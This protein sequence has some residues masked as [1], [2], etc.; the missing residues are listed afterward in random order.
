MTWRGSACP[1]PV[2]PAR[3]TRLPAGHA[4]KVGLVPFRSPLEGA[5]VRIKSKGA[6]CVREVVAVEEMGTHLELVLAGMPRRAMI[7]GVLGAW[8]GPCLLAC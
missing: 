1:S 2:P 5:L 6:Y 4:G 3:P 7:A 8:G